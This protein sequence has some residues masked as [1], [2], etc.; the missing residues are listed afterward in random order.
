MAMQQMPE[1]WGRRASES[2]VASAT[3][4]L[5]SAIEQGWIGMPPQDVAADDRVERL[6]HRQLVHQ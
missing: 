5:G 3:D 1:D 2:S 4:G 6:G